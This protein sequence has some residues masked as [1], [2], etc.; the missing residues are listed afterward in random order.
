MQDNFLNNSNEKESPSLKLRFNTDEPEERNRKKLILSNNPILNKNK[1]N[2]TPRKNLNDPNK[3]EE[4]KVFQRSEFKPYTIAN[5][6]DP[7]KFLGLKANP[8]TSIEK[9]ITTMNKIKGKLTLYNEDD[10]VSEVD[11]VIK[12]LLANNIYK[13]KIHEKISKEENDFY[14]EYSN[15]R[16][17]LLLSKDISN[18]G[19]F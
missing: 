3:T 5:I 18:Y 7:R 6:T 11:W 10:L 4:T 1:T 16:S 9:I 8:Q 2:F 17:E 12:E 15:N 19:K 13:L 14:D